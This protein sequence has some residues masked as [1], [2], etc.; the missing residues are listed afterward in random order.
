MAK[1]TRKTATPPSTRLRPG[2]KAIF[3]ISITIAPIPT[4]IQSTPAKCRGICIA[5]CG[6]PTARFVIDGNL[7]SVEYTDRLSS[8]KVPTLILVGDHDECDPSL[9]KVMQEKISGSKLMICPS[10]GHMTF[11]DQP[12]IFV[13]AVDDFLN[14]R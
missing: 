14:A 12:G 3:P 7:K 6:V 1:I 4:M 8:I 9:A 11:V 13:K 2:A 5:R 10:Q